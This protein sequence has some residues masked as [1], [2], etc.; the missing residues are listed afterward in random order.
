L[1]G[2]ENLVAAVKRFHEHAR[3]FTVVS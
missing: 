2:V 1:V 3:D